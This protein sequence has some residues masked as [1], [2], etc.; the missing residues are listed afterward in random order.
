MCVNEY[1]SNSTYIL[2][3]SLCDEQEGGTLLVIP[4]RGVMWMIPVTGS[5]HLLVQDFEFSNEDFGP[6]N[7]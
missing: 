5:E 4:S 7:K 1:I 6:D 3:R 2:Q